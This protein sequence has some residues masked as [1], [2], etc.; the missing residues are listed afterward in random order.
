LWFF[1]ISWNAAKEMDGDETVAALLHW[2][3]QRGAHFSPS[4]AV[5]DGDAGRGVFC[6]A[7]VRS[8][9]LLLRLPDSMA[10]RPLGGPIAALVAHGECSQLLGLV[11][12]LVHELFVAAPRKPFFALLAA[13]PLPRVPCLWSAAERLHLVGTSLALAVAEDPCAIYETDVL[14]WMQKLGEELFP[15]AARTQAA[16]EA[17]LS[18][19]LSRGFRGLI[20]YEMGHNFPYLA[21]D[22]PPPSAQGG[23]YMLPLVDLLN[24]SSDPALLSTVLKSVELEGEG[25]RAFEMRA[26]RDLCEGEE[27]LHSYG[28]HDAAELVR[29]YGFCDAGAPAY[30]WTAKISRDELL[31]AA[32]TVLRQGD[33]S[34]QAA[35]DLLFAQPWMPVVFVVRRPAAGI[36]EVALPPHLLSAVQVLAFSEE[37]FRA[38]SEAGCIPLGEE[39]LDDES[40]MTVVSCLTELVTVCIRRYSP[41]PPVAAATSATSV[42][43]I[44]QTL[45]NEELRLLG[46]LKKAIL[47]VY[48]R[49][50]EAQDGHGDEDEDEDREEDEGEKEVEW[51]EERED[52]RPAKRRNTDRN[53][54][55]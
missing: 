51:E 15:P 10:V 27:V 16:F 3:T 17:A 33:S 48:F 31:Q 55:E 21:A 13:T 19:A 4:L 25:G 53:T 52:M 42:A 24:H 37:E 50:E 30:V 26:S 32:R 5:R 12:T 9:D 8:G 45:R 1:F 34:L 35:A 39:Y 43:T 41:A 49:F 38:W 44:G 28:A 2:A 20:S 54:A 47:S 22:G 11:L 29:T 6:V 46:E 14:P 23:P 7:A 18:W 40:I 36:M